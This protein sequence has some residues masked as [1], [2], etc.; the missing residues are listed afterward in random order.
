MLGETLEQRDSSTR[1][2][3]GADRP[4]RAPRRRRRHRRGCA[5]DAVDELATARTSRRAVG[6]ARQQPR[7]PR[8]A[9]D[10]AASRLNRCCPASSSRMPS[11]RTPRGRGL[12]TQPLYLNAV[13]VGETDLNA[14]HLLDALL[15]IEGPNTAANVP[16]NAP[17]RSISTSYSS[18][19]RS[20]RTPGLQLPHPRFRERFF[21]L[22]PLAEIA[23]D[24]VDPGDGPPGGG[25]VAETAAGRGDGER[26]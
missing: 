25:T 22:G 4:A 8:A 14:R 10:F 26:R 12:R 6:R 13:A 20:S 19:T 21:V 11:R 18:A 9:L 17:A 5:S 3:P 2:S 24:M 1:R 7:Q 15:A 23:P 16:P